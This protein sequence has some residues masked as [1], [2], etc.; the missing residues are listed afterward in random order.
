MKR[1][2]I[3]SSI[4]LLALVF[5]TSALPQAARLIPPSTEESNRAVP[6]GQ[7][8]SHAE[9]HFHPRKH[10]PGIQADVPKVARPELKLDLDFEANR[11]Q[12]AAQ[13]AFVAHGPTY[14]LGLSSTEIALSL[15]RPREAAQ[16]GSLP[17]VL[18]VSADKRLDAMDHAQL[19]LR[20]MGANRGSSLSGMEPRPGVSNYFIGNDPS[21]WQTHVPHFG[22]V[23]MDGIYPGIDLVFYGNPQQ[24][25]Y[26]FQVAPGADPRT[27]H[28]NAGNATST[29]LDR[30]GDLVLATSAGDVRLRH[31][32]AYQVVDG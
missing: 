17:A 5:R 11:G 23:K 30:E 18:N 12:A 14:A 1:L 28:L 8:A 7:L 27:I 29:A 13:Y 16:A 19:H 26:D 4:G 6:T 10:A 3:I 25:E 24:L 32:N 22:R 2:L 9:S 31:P 20:F 21:K 15:N